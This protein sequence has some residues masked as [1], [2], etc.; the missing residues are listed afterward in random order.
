MRFSIW[1]SLMR[2]VDEVLEVA[3]HAERTGWD[4]VYVAD[5]FMGDGGGFGPEESPTLEATAVLAALAVA[6]ERVRLGPLVLGTTYRQ[7]TVV[8]KWAATVDHL[9]GGRLVLGV[10]A[11][12]QQNEHERYG[13]EL[14]AV[15]A[16]VERFAEVCL[17]LTGLLR[18]HRTTF[19]GHWF[20]LDDAPCE[21]K[22]VQR[23]LPLL[24]GA[25]GDRMLGVVA[26]HADEWNLWGLPP[27]IAER[28]AV[29]ERHCESVGRDPSE[30]RRSTQALI[31][32]TSDPSE[33]RAFLDAVAPRAAVAG[34]WEHILET[35]DGWVA[36][37][38]DE[39]IVPD[40]T[41]GRGQERL[42]RM[43]AFLAA[44]APFRSP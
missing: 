23:H 31:L 39:L 30:I 41:L 5:H 18:E 15:G 16:R 1:P 6:T 42:D 7:P 19:D 27:W 8:A 26:R 33:A 10:G 38:V 20:H 35:V 36:V 17:V 9:S 11:G 3:T 24:I 43:D 21:P 22:P 25:K 12:W 28:S 14:P 44:V 40:N 29:L 4:G 2:P 32:P 37:G 13:I 34:P